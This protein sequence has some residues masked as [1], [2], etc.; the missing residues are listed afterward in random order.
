M[1]RV[2]IALGATLLLGACGGEASDAEG[3][4]QTAPA[5][6]SSGE[7]V[8]PEPAATDME[9]AQDSQANFPP[10]PSM[11]V[12][13]T[14]SDTIDIRSE[15]PALQF[16]PARVSAANGERILLR[17]QNGGELPHNFA[18]FLR[19]DGIDEWVSAAYEASASGYIPRAA[20]SDLIAYSPLL[21]PGEVAE[22]EFVVP[23]PG[24]YTY[25]CL[26]PGHAQMML[27]TFTSR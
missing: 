5:P 15:G 4:S 13:G 23:S 6:A 14:A 17:Y 2:S 26:F 10:L 3:A 16:L 21:S 18:L 22:M 27:G 19:E 20:A 9:G 24:T 11:E 25:I 8:A 1:R 12:T 7:A